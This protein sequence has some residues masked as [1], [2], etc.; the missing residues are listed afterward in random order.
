V[1][2][3]KRKG[4]WLSFGSFWA[5]SVD[6]KLKRKSYYYFMIQW[7]VQKLFG[8]KNYALIVV[9]TPP[10]YRVTKNHTL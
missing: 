10:N 2:E 4:G 9:L 8:P 1:V 7:Q 6:K 5:V 3:E